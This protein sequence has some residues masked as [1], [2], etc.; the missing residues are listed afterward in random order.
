MRW[1][2]RFASPSVGDTTQRWF[3]WGSTPPPATRPIVLTSATTARHLSTN[4]R[5]RPGPTAQGAGGRRQP[6]NQGHPKMSPPKKKGEA[7]PSIAPRSGARSAGGG[8]NSRAQGANRRRLHGCGR[9]VGSQC[10]QT[11]VHRVSRPSRP[12]VARR[13]SAPPAQQPRPPKGGSSTKH[14]A[15]PG[16]ASQGA[17]GRRLHG[18]SRQAHPQHREAKPGEREGGRLAVC[19]LPRA[20]PSNAG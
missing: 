17:G 7:P 10:R 18:F 13:G 8:P 2:G 15:R 3:R 9:Q 16:V 6:N 5:A 11:R 12:R 1:I 14:R 20:A 4:H 19:R